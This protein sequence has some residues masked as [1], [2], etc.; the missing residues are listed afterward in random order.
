[1]TID[2]LV[3]LA[4]LTACAFL[5][6]RSYRSYGKS[7]RETAIMAAAWVGIFVTLALLLNALGTGE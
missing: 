7:G 5:A 2:I 1:M 3:M 4:A 6:W